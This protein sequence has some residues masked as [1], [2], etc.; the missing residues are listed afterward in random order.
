MAQYQLLDTASMAKYKPNQ[1]TRQAS[2]AVVLNAGVNPIAGT[3]K[4]LAPQATLAKSPTE[5]VAVATG[6]PQAQK[7]FSQGYQLEQKIPGPSQL[8]NYTQTNAVGT[9]LYGISKPLSSQDLG[10]NAGNSLVDARNT[11]QNMAKENDISTFESYLNTLDVNKNTARQA[12]LDA[13]KPSED[14]TNIGNQ[15][16]DVQDKGVKF[17]LETQNLQSAQDFN[18]NLL[19]SQ[20]Q[21][22]Q[23]Q[24]E[25]ERSFKMQEYKLDEANLINR[26]GLAQ[27]AQKTAIDA[28]KFGY[29]SVLDDA[30]LAF[31][32]QERVD[33]QKQQA[34][35]NAATLQ[36]AA[37]QKATLAMN[38]FKEGLTNGQDATA[39]K[40][41]IGLLLSQAGIDPVISASMFD[42][43]Q[44][45]VEYDRLKEISTAGQVSATT[46]ANMI[47]S[48]VQTGLSVEEATSKVSQILGAT[49]GVGGG[50]TG[51]TNTG[52]QT[53]GAVGSGEGGMRT[54]RHNNPTA[55]TTDVAKTLGLVEGKDYTKGDAFPNN[56]NLFTARLTGDGVATTVKA[57]DLAASDPNKKAFY[58]QGGQQRWTHTAMS[59]EAWLKMT[60]EQKRNAVGGM[61]QREGGDGSLFSGTPT[62]TTTPGVSSKYSPEVINAAE[63]IKNGELSVDDASIKPLAANIRKY[64]DEAKIAVPLTD[65]QIKTIEA[66]PE[67]KKIKAN[68]DLKQKLTNYQTLIDEYGTELYGSKAALL[69]QAYAEAK[70]AW[71]EAANLGALT[72]PDVGIIQTALKEATGLAGKK[73]ALLYGEQGIKDGVQAALNTLLASTVSNMKLL[74]S[75]NKNYANSDYVK[76]LKEQAGV[77]GAGQTSTAPSGITYTIKK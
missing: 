12:V 53:F 4:P 74:E 46:K 16:A 50:V 77:L 76:A 71:K 10:G 31:K 68:I 38:A 47:N 44:S 49:G 2:G 15:L 39:L 56:P 14:V 65:Q 52:G 25:R 29:T 30:N 40:S 13:S 11:N 61:Y 41:S 59:D 26:L 43:I 22:S 36:G 32:I 18:P 20:V 6:T 48:L 33:T 73:N 69:E 17:G 58:T 23:A 5:R 75:K 34:L 72:G 37:L 45:G 64:M 21:K 42:A 51:T 28:A 9:A 7:L 27:D 70:I 60:P 54:D 24:I 19:T 55:M 66:S 3:F 67:G 8:P 1:Y 63:R 35:T 62:N 57:L